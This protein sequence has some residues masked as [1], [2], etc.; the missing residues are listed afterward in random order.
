MPSANVPTCASCPCCG[1]EVILAK[2][3]VLRRSST[4][5]SVSAAIAELA[6]RGTSFAHH[7]GQDRPLYWA[8][9]DCIRAKRAL[10]T[11]PRKQKWMDCEPY[12]AYYDET[13][14][15]VDC[16]ESF[17]FAKEEQLHWYETL[18][19]WVWSRPI[20][21]AACNARRS[22]DRCSLLGSAIRCAPFFRGENE[23]VR[24]VLRTLQTEDPT[25]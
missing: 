1:N 4:N 21:C 10:R 15:C 19:F 6:A 24:G 12:L 20:R 13:R 14:I 9:D 11:E 2:Q 3:S 7:S 5:G 25:S 16:G 17:V 22:A 23:S 18:Q 8:C